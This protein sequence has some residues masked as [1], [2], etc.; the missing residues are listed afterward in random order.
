MIYLKYWAG[1]H[2]VGDELSAYIVEKITN[3]PVEYASLNQQKCLVA[4]GS[5]LHEKTLYNNDV[6]WG[7]GFL[8]RNSIKRL[9]RFKYLI[10]GL[11]N[12]IFKKSQICALRG[13]LSGA[14]CKSLG[15]I[16]P[17][18]YGDPA[19]LLP[20]YYSPQKKQTTH[21]A[22]LIL[23][24][25]HESRFSTGSFHPNIKNISV[26]RQSFTEIEAFVDE[27]L[28]CE[29]IY[30]TSLHGIIIAQAYGIPAQWIM[31]NEHD[32]HK[33]P[34]FKF[35]DYFLGVEQIRQQPYILQSLS[36]NELNKM[37][38]IPPPKI[39]SEAID[40]HG[41]MLLKAFP[42]HLIKKI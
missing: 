7:T 2:N 1:H 42:S 26:L 6:I 13:P 8:K 14:I 18:I 15:F 31:L 28:Q 21:K 32:I 22:G 3:Q 39:S 10:P 41:E 30:S 11:Y 5:F 16:D 17:Q 4:I 40:F 9:P 37:L 24:H 19:I 35:E 34:M 12:R 36:T 29:V 33:D 23:H 27:I 38:E 20:K 25:S